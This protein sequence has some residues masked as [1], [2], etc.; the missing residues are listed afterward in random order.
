MWCY[1]HKTIFTKHGRVQ[2]QNIIP[3][4]V[5]F[6]HYSSHSIKIQFIKFLERKFRKPNVRFPFFKKKYSLNST[7]R[8][9]CRI[10]LQDVVLKEVFVDPGVQ[11]RLFSHQFRKPLETG[12]AIGR[13]N[14]L[15]R[16]TLPN[17]FSLFCAQPKLA[18]SKQKTKEVQSF[19]HLQPQQAQ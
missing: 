3:K 7:L 4:K 11:I 8:Q 2:F 16:K 1:L 15:L 14:C 12:L 17:L 5:V 13:E 9:Q 18:V 6:I 10:Q 19:L